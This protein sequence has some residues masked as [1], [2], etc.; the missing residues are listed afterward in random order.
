MKRN[1]RNDSTAGLELFPIR[2]VSTLTGVNSITLR[3]WERR[4]GLVQPI[5]T[6]TGHRL[7]RQDEIDLIHRVVAFLEKG[8]S[9][10][11]VR[12]AL[13]RESQEEG[14]PNKPEDQ[15][16]LRLR[17]R[18]STAL[19]RL[20]EE[21][22]DQ[23]YNEALG[24]ASVDRVTQ[25]LLMP[26]LRELGR[27]S[28]TGAGSPAEEAFFGMYLRNKLGARMHHRTHRSSCPRFLG[29]CM[30]GEYRETELLLFALAAHEAGLSPVLLG[31]NTPLAELGAAAQRGRC[32][33]IVLSGSNPAESRWPSDE[34][35][36]LCSAANVPVFIAGSVS[37]RYRDEL[38]AVGAVPLG[39]D[40]ASGTRRIVD[41]LSA[42]QPLNG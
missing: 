21:A 8:I 7:Y 33:A 13:E 24:L 32:K 2:T 6:P 42:P 4:Y 30:P 14:S 36:R 34:L 9:I 3:A 23:I 38:V 27:R 20:D 39:N 22:L 11:Q 28:E 19:I 29:A 31:T 5:R 41:A 10:S 37:L 18:M 26:L 15:L 17:Q 16:W 1:E 25:D 40:L 35:P 12:K